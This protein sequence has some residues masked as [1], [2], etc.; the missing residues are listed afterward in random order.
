MRTFRALIVDDERLARQELAYLLREHPQIEIVGEA[1]SLAAAVEAI[2]RLDPDLVFLD[3]QMPGGNSLEMFERLKLRGQVIFVTA[4]DHY[5]LRAFEVNALD[6]LM[7]PVHPARLATAI[8]RFIGESGGDSVRPAAPLA[9]LRYEDPV[10]VTIGHAPRFIP[11]PAIAC[12]LAE[13]DYTRV[14]G[15][16]GDIGL[17]LRSLTEWEQILP[18]RYFV[19]VQRSTIV[20]CAHIA[21]MEPWFNGAFRVHLQGRSAPL[22]MSRRYARR[23]RRDYKT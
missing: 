16:S 11:L 10:F 23:F 15:L 18:E 6:Y 7:K 4:H 19:R 3:V 13:G 5:A 17:V 8:A 21:R 12:V 2:A 1:G 22:I 14:V 20:N 9:R